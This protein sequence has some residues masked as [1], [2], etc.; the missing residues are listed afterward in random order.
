MSTGTASADPTA[1]AADPDQTAYGFA[2]ALL[3]DDAA[4]A[5]AY[6]ATEA[7]LMTAD[8]TE[9]SGAAAIKEVL[10][11]IASSE[12]QL[13]IRLG[14]TLLAGPVALSTQYWRRTGA[15]GAEPFER[16]NT[17]SLVLQREGGR[18]AILI[19]SPWG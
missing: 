17:A 1:V 9:V 5:A 10:G 8:G 7:R 19:A 14:R 18:W 15:G 11:Q 3:G 6:F 12:V 16:S 2:R 13:E 4:A